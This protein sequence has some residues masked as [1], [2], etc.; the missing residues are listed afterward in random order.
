MKQTFNFERSSMNLDNERQ[1]SFV[2]YVGGMKEM[3]FIQE[4]VRI[5]E[6]CSP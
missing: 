1:L 5:P 3:N 4:Q 6:Q 2:H